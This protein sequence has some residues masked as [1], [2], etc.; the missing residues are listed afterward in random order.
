MGSN[1]SFASRRTPPYTSR[2]QTSA[3]KHIC[4]IDMWITC[5]HR[6]HR[7]IWH[8]PAKS[9]G[10]YTWRNRILYEWDWRHLRTWW[11]R[12]IHMSYVIHIG[13]IESG[14]LTLLVRKFSI[15]LLHI[16]TK[17]MKRRIIRR[18]LGIVKPYAPRTLVPAGQMRLTMSIYIYTYPPRGRKLEYEPSYTS[19]QLHMRAQSRTY[20]GQ[21]WDELA[22]TNK[23][24]T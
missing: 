16:P 24:L 22:W 17:L 11:K 2:W 20:L 14:F 1:L 7:C 6:C 5:P 13:L 19:S 9:Q 10:M 18:T 21:A 3:C 15:C 23:H 4:G 12:G 8:T